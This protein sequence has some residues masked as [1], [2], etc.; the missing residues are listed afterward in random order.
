MDATLACWPI[1]QMSNVKVDFGVI[2]L[3]LDNLAS[4]Q[5]RPVFA[6]LFMADHASRDF[7][8]AAPE[9]HAYDCEKGQFLD[10]VQPAV[11]QSQLLINPCPQNVELI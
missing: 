9:G 2:V 11:E 4:I 8:A 7:G 3:F 1:M 5:C 10:I 6:K